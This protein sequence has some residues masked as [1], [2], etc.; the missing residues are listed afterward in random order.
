M[1]HGTY[2]IGT[3]LVVSIFALFKSQY[4]LAWKMMDPRE[5]QP[6][7]DRACP[8]KAAGKQAIHL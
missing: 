8:R 2:D 6:R 5:T 1:T 7:P 4:V 3:P